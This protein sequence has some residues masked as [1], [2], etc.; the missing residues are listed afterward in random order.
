MNLRSFGWMRHQ[1]HTHAGFKNQRNMTTQPRLLLAAAPQQRAYLHLSMHTTMAA[2]LT[3]MT[4]PHPKAKGCG[5]ALCVFV[6]GIQQKAPMSKR[7]AG[8]RHVSPCMPAQIPVA[9][10]SIQESK[11]E[12]KYMRGK[13]STIS[14]AC[15]QSFAATSM[16]HLPQAHHQ[17]SCK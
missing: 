5:L 9:R 10:F 7:K 14:Q 17:T 3:C 15:F 11:R 13:P 16:L 1:D 8:C 6:G 4:K 12:Y 2:L